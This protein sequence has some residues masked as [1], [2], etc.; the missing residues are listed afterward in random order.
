MPRDEGEAEM[1][2]MICVALAGGYLSLSDI[3]E[4]AADYL[5][6]AEDD[7]ARMAARLV[8]E[9]ARRQAEKQAAVPA[10][11][12]CDRLDRAFAVLEARDIFCGQHLGYDQ[13]D[14]GDRMMERIGA[15]KADARHARGRNHSP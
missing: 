6:G 13:G 1:S 3:E 10:T 4:D 14:G 8:P 7:L 15:E 2:E 11:T 9:L 5:I 12:D